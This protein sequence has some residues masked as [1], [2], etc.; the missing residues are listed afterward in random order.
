MPLEQPSKVSGPERP[1]R[2][3]VVDD[4]SFMR[5]ALRKIIEA[6]GDMS[7]VGE[8]RNG[9]EAVKL[10]RELKP[11]AITMDVE[12]PG[13][14]GL[15]ACARILREAAPVPFIIMVSATPRPAPTRRYAP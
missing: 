15:D 9:E 13:M 4:Q 1:I 5:I 3:L 14:D 11:D 10:A 6:E 8:A 7:V 2:V 12:M